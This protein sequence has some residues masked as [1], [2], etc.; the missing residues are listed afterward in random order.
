MKKAKA[1]W[2]LE[3]ERD[4]DDSLTGFTFRSQT[5]SAL[6]FD[7]Q[8]FHQQLQLFRDEFA[9]ALLVQTPSGPNSCGGL[10]V[11]RRYAGGRP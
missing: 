4:R 8:G 1:R 11:H 9:P 5:L 3:S 6:T 2:S 7:P 10:R